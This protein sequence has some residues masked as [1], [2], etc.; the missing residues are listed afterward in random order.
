MDF[1]RAVAI[2]FIL[3]S[4][5]VIHLDTSGNKKAMYLAFFCPGVLHSAVT[6]TATTA[7]HGGHVG[8]HH[9]FCLLSL[10]LGMFWIIF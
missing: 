6:T 3:C 7:D 9:F 5:K 1:S 2:T 8:F 10:F 4:G